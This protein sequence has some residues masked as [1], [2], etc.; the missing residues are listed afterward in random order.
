M[1]SRH[2]KNFHGVS[3]LFFAFIH[4]SYNFTVPLTRRR[5]RSAR[6]AAK[7]YFKDIRKS[8]VKVNQLKAG[9]FL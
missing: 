1:I 5:Q 3:L 9:V 7:T 8:I 6:A 4:I 2:N